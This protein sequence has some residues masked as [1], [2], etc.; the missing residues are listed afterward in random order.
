MLQR[1]LTRNL[2]RCGGF[3]TRRRLWPGLRPGER[4][5][6]AQTT[7]VRDIDIDNRSV[8]PRPCGTTPLGKWSKTGQTRVANPQQDAVGLQTRLN[9]GGAWEVRGRHE[10]DAWEDARLQTR[11]DV[12]GTWKVRGRCLGGTRKMRGCKPAWTGEVR[13]EDTC[14]ARRLQRKLMRLG[15]FLGCFCV[16][17]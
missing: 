6:I 3:A 1:G 14:E 5:K 17:G 2:P 11:L 12:G 4:K 10:E 7:R 13:G 15:L 9:V 16:S 8:C